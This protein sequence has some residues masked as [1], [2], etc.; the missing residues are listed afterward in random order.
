MDSSSSEVFIFKNI[1]GTICSVLTIMLV[2]SP[3]KSILEGL[4]TMEI[5]NIALTYLVSAIASGIFWGT[6]GLKLNDEPI[7]IS[8]LFLILLYTFY[9]NCYFFI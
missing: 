1:V 7:Y 9:L 3:M 2:F 5:K 4:R 6:Y 8:N